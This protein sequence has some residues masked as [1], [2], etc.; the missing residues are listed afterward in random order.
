M[1]KVKAP[2]QI[3][4]ELSELKTL[5]R[6]AVE[7]IRQFTDDRAT[8]N[9]DIAADVA[10]LEAQGIHRKALKW[11]MTYAE[12]DDDTR[13]GFDA[14]YALVRESLG[15]PFEDQLFDANGQPNIKPKPAKEAKAATDA[16]EIAQHVLD[17]GPTLN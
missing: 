6:S 12:W 1:A 7:R 5:I 13:A 14:A 3:S 2:N 17:A 4:K 15:V 16:E 8:S 10:A 9:A 11:A